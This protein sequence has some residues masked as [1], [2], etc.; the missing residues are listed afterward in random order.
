VKENT[1]EQKKAARSEHWRER[2][3][4]QERSGLSVQR[5]CAEQGLSEQSFYVWR[6]RLRNQQPMRFALVETEA[7]Q[8]QVATEA[9]LELVL[10]TGERLRISAGVDLTVLRGVLEVLRA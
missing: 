1:P 6:K 4:Q 5:F 3:V 2:I 10:A 9:G 8:R 7:A